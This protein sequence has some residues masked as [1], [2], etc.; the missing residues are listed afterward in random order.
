MILPT[1][2]FC[3]SL[4]FFPY[5]IYEKKEKWV[6]SVKT[7]LGCRRNDCLTLFAL[8]RKGGEAGGAFF[9]CS[10]D[11]FAVGIIR[12]FLFCLSYQ[13]EKPLGVSAMVFLHLSVMLDQ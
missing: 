4:V 2:L 13:A 1:L 9:Q 7:T 3:P 5:E 11:L 8:Q 6:V 12:D 10:K